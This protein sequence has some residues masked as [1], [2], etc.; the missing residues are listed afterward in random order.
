MPHVTPDIGLPTLAY[1]SDGQR[2]IGEIDGWPY[3]RAGWVL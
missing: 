1:R 2:L 3:R